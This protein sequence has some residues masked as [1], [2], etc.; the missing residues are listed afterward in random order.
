MALAVP[1]LP[2]SCRRSSSSPSSSIRPAAARGDSCTSHR[3]LLQPAAFCPSSVVSSPRRLPRAPRRT[4]GGLS[5]RGARPAEEPCR[6]RRG[7]LR[8]EEAQAG[9]ESSHEAAAASSPQPPLQGRDFRGRREVLVRE[10]CADV[11]RSV[12]PFRALDLPLRGG[13]ARADNLTG[14][15]GLTAGGDHVGRGIA[16]RTPLAAITRDHA[17]VWTGGLRVPRFG[18]RYGGSLANLGTRSGHAL[19]INS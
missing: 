19:A 1:Y 2:C 12:P 4:A 7:L 17:E 16:G 11:E 14:I 6:G 3:R 10:P 15:P 5:N 18:E 13:N 8:L 9:G